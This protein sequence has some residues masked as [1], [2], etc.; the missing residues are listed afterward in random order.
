MF[1][2]FDGWI[3]NWATNMN[4]SGDPYNGSID[5]T[6]S[7][8]DSE[9][10]ADSYASVP[11]TTLLG[12]G[13]WCHALNCPANDVLASWFG[14]AAS[15]NVYDVTVTVND[16]NPPS[17]PS[18]G[19]SLANLPTWVSAAN[20]G[21]GWSLTTSA[22]DPGGICGIQLS[23]GGEQATGGNP[24]NNTEAAPCGGSASATLN[25]NPCELPDGPYTISESA[26][27]PAGMTGYGPLNGQTIRIDC[28][29]PTTSIASAPSSSMWYSTPQQVDFTGSDNYSGVGSVN[30]NDGNHPGSSYT[31]AV[32]AEGTSTVSCYAVD[33][34]GNDGN[35]A[36]ATVNLDYQTPSVLFSGASSTGW[37]SGT[38][39]L[40]V[41]GSE[42]QPLSGIASVSCQVNGGA[43]TTTSG[44][45]QTVKI[46][47]DGT[48]TITC[49]ATTGA[50]ITSAPASY[51]VQVDS[52]PPTLVFS[53]GPDQGTWSRTAESIT[54]SAQDQPGLSGLNEIQCTL[55]ANT[56][57][58]T[59]SPVQITVQPPGGQ[60]ICKAEDNAGNWS[61]PQAW[62]FL[63]D[64]DPP[65][66][67]FLPTSPSNPTLVQVQ[68]ADTGS[69]VAGARI[70]IQTAAGWELLPTTWDASTGIA[71]ATIPDDG[72]IPDG[73]HA[74]EALAWDVAGNQ[75]TI[76]QGPN[77]GPDAITL[78][79]RVVTD[80]KVGAGRVLNRTCRT[81][82]QVIRKAHGHRA[83]RAAAARLVTSCRLTPAPGFASHLRLR[84]GQEQTINGQLQTHE[85]TPL[86]GATVTVTATA[87][88]WPARTLGQ[89]TTD[90]NGKFSYT[91]AAVVSE[92]LT[93]SYQGTDTLRTTVGQAALRVLGR[94][95]IQVARRAVAG[96]VLRI[97]GRVL[98]GYIPAGGVLVQLQYRVRGVPV[99]WAPFDQAI[100]TGRKGRFS[101][102]FPLNTGA[103][104]YTYL[105][106]AAIQKQNGW[107]F[108]TTTTNAVARHVS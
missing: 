102:E 43:P 35:T 70:E 55:G 3:A 17:F 73:T 33:N 25:L 47:T 88:G 69:G 49:T 19:G 96:H 95:R 79:L 8:C 90:A 24:D 84:Y 34:A 12:F 18:D 107:P 85:G 45:T 105:F 30:C 2:A 75:A 78:P 14:P 32:S 22:S 38:Q 64:D 1:S 87:S 53:G 63:I 103:R 27:N 94:A 60:L 77:A 65:T 11:N 9:S 80:M 21:G 67:Q 31:E 72:S 4:G 98:G 81:H 23:I 16:R 52:E 58:Y 66:G 39:G 91:A 62:Q 15:A 46:S 54:V 42:Y 59:T 71:S 92:V 10:L 108:L 50:G 99:G 61:A 6:G 101:V 44:P 104:G 68:L 106:N 20:A 100:H 97:T 40:T 36:G 7:P 28:T 37:V 13:I 57:T 26:T 76:T 5:C 93:F 89:T 86:A 41:T 51:T 48:D 29:P 83:F 82:R 74:L 56:S